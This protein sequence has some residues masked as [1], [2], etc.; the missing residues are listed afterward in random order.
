VKKVDDFVHL[1]FTDGAIL[2][3]FT[4]QD[5]VFAVPADLDRCARQMT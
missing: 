3:T 1:T 2:G 5:I 4:D